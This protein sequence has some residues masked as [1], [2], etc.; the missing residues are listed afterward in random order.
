MI[1][2]I[3]NVFI[4]IGIMSLV[5]VAFVGMLGP[6]NSNIQSNAED[7]MNTLN[8]F[9]SQ[10]NETKQSVSELTN[11]NPSNSDL[12]AL[13]F[14]IGAVTNTILQM[15]GLILSFLQLPLQVWISYTSLQW[16]H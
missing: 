5:F 11:V 12:D 10:V 7:N 9:A 4:G 14:A 2:D 8:N 13:A 3:K 15:G 1:M 16:I 6:F